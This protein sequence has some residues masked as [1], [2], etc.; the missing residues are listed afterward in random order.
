M[1]GL[2]RSVTARERQ[3]AKSNLC[4]GYVMLEQLETALAYC[5]E[6]LADND[7]HWRAYSNRAL[8]NVK[9]KRYAEAEQDLQKGEAISP[10][11]R[12]L[13]AVRKMLLDATNPVAP[14][15]VIDDRRRA[16]DDADED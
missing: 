8:A 15:I 3:T 16:P 1:I 10:K 12:T 11:A 9:L 2:R 4:A 7:Q 5:D 14:I 6:V 13:K